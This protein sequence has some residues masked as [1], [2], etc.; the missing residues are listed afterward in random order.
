MTRTEATALSKTTVRIYPVGRTDAGQPY[1]DG[2]PA[3]TTD[4]DPVRAE[5]LV[6]T[7]AFTY[8]EPEPALAEPASPDE[9]TD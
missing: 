9:E 7:G 5:W 8:T 2:V 1:I 4:C 6:S 3:T